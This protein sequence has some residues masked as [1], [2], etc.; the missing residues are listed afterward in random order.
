MIDEKKK[1]WYGYARESID[2]KNGMQVQVEAIERYAEAYDMDLEDTYGD[3]DRSA[4]KYRP[5][6]EEL[7]KMIPEMSGIIV[8]ELS[9]FGRDFQDL[10]IK[11]KQ[12][13]ESGVHL[14]CIREG[15]DTRR[16]ECEFYLHL[17]MLL[18]HRERELQRERC[19]A[20]TIYAMKNGTRTGRPWGR[21]EIPL[22]WDEYEKYN[23]MGLSDARIAKILGM[24]RST[25]C[26][27]LKLREQGDDK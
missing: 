18:A 3:N 13:K 20:G 1:P 9:R 6:F 17:L 21:P 25:L 11:W 8:N 22:D 10:V 14:I 12:M 4:Y 23:R 16:P 19:K 5:E 27:R 26:K 15:I 24:H 7:W 2:L